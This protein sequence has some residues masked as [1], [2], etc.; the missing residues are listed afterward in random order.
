MDRF[1]T[2]QRDMAAPDPSRPSGGDDV[3]GQDPSRW[4]VILAV[5]L[6]IAALVTATTIAVLL[7]RGAPGAAP[8]GP[9]ED[10]GPT[11]SQGVEGPGSAQ[12]GTVDA[13]PRQLHPD[14]VVSIFLCDGRVCPPITGE[15][16]ASLEASLAGDGRIAEVHFESSAEA[17]ERFLELFADQPHLTASVDEDTLPESFRVWLHDPAFADDVAAGFI[18]HPGVE[19]VVVNTHPRPP[20]DLDQ[21]ARDQDLIR[22]AIDSMAALAVELCDGRTCPEASDDERRAIEA[23]LEAHPLVADVTF[24]SGEEAYD[25]LRGTF[26]ESPG[27][28]EQATPDLFA[29]SYEV[30][31]VDPQA[32]FDDPGVFTDVAEELR[33]LPGVAMLRDRMH[34]L[35]EPLQR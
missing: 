22:E 3:A 5:S 18:D 21:Q 16:R 17:Y 7:N 33:H 19:E 24:R 12:G 34:P 6:L 10:R 4:P 25:Q 2:P 31:V 23:A 15:E 13:S 1:G 14:G 20:H 11:P 8:L 30:W 27:L 9:A 26:A 35:R 32:Y 28:L 29:D